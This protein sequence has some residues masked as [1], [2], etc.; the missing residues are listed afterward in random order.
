MAKYRIRVDLTY[1]TTG[2]A[3]TA[4]TNINNVLAARTDPVIPERA[5]RASARVTVMVAGLEQAQAQALLAALQPA[6]PVGAR[7]A[8]KVSMVRSEDVS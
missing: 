5:T 6:W 8:G 1:S 7:T 2:N 4:T 3:T